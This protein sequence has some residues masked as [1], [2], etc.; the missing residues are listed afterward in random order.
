MCSYT[1]MISL[2][3]KQCTAAVREHFTAACFEAAPS[4]FSSL[5]KKQKC[6]FCCLALILICSCTF[7]AVWNLPAIRVVTTLVT[8]GNNCETLRTR[9]LPSLS[10]LM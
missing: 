10:R 4:L 3:L 7:C 8:S 9:V 6:F 2:R 5:Q 1:H